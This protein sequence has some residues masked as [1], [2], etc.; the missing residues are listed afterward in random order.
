MNTQSQKELGITQMQ[1]KVNRNLI[2][3]YYEFN[4]KASD[5]LWERY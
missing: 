5:V 3:N 2:I 1:E 4:L